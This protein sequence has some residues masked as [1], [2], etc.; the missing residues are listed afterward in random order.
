MYKTGLRGIGLGITLGLSAMAAVPALAQQ[1]APAS[2]VTDL[3]AVSNDALQ[4]NPGYA[5]ARAELAAAQETVPQ[6]VGKLLPQVG[7]QTQYDYVHE[8]V[9]GDYYGVA[10]IDRSD[11]FDRWVYGAKLKQ[12][13]YQPS[14]FIG[15][16]QA[17]LKVQ[18]AGLTFQAEQD[19]LLMQVVEAYFGV[20]ASEDAVAFAGAEMLAVGQQR[21]QVRARARAGLATDADTK[22]ATA[23]YELAVANQTDAG[24]AL[25]NALARL[26]ALTGRYYGQ[27]KRLPLN[28]LLIPPQPQ[29]EQVWIDRARQA[30][31]TLL[32]QQI[33]LEVAKLEYDK[34]RKLRWP[35]LDLVG[36]TFALDSGGGITGQRDERSER[37]GVVLDL[38]LYSGGQISATKRQ[39]L[40]LQERAEA[41]YDDARARVVRDTRIAYRNS[42]AGLQRV[43]ALKRALDAAVAAEEATRAGFD[44]GTRTSADVLSAVERRYAAERDHSASRYQFLTASLRL[45]Q[46]SGNLLVADL[47]QINRMLE[48]RPSAPQP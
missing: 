16:K 7:F 5:A 35:T 26:E 34:S 13:L 28:L 10:N 41:L 40:A 9:E 14:L 15:R 37:I 6:A 25:D 48:Y 22:A 12:A 44:A 17:E 27:V 45:K 11:D 36:Q 4:F 19:A 39:S 18:R 43:A 24:V 33:A 46:L 3:L 20:L 32:A 23:Q 2:G 8:S 42:S 31:P 29:Q 38:P 47:A 21:D 30:N 1:A